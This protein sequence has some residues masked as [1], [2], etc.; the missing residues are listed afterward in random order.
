M[1]TTYI[2]TGKPSFWVKDSGGSTILS[3]AST[4][5]SYPPVYNRIIR[6]KRE[7]SFVM[8]DGTEKRFT[9]GAQYT[10]EIFYSSGM[11]TQEV[12]DKLIDIDE[13]DGS[14]SYT[15]YIKPRE[16]GSLTGECIIDIAFAYKDDLIDN[17]VD[18]TITWRL[19]ELV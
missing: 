4:D 11:L 8:A 1:A 6:T 2:G 14:D 13:Y 12:I 7:E 9:A 5:I 19:S 10:G 16:D 18:V 3:I 17:G 15:C